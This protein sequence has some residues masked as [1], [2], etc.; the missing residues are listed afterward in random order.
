M[1]VDI[2]DSTLE[3]QS[4][5]SPCRPHASMNTPMYRIR[6]IL[7]RRSRQQ[8]RRRERNIA[9]AGYDMYNMLMHGKKAIP[10]YSKLTYLINLSDCHDRCA[11]KWS[12]HRQHTEE[13]S[14]LT[15]SDLH[16]R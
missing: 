16:D 10:L 2:E 12:M 3:R 15:V 14:T 8:S 7:Y 13:K 1:H 5:E 11:R 6:S 4:Q 9:H